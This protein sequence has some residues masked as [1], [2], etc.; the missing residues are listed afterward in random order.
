MRYPAINDHPE[1]RVGIPQLSGGINVS[2]NPSYINDN[3][4]TACK[5]M[6]FSSGRL[7][8]RPGISLD[9]VTGIDQLYTCIIGGKLYLLSSRDINGKF[10]EFDI[11][12]GFIVSISSDQQGYSGDRAA[13]FV[14]R[15]DDGALFIYGYNPDNDLKEINPYIPTV[16]INVNPSLPTDIP[17][18][19]MYQ[20][21]NLLTG[22]YKIACNTVCPGNKYW[23][24]VLPV[25][26]ANIDS[27]KIEY[28]D[29]NHREQQNA[30]IRVSGNTSGNR[31]QSGD[32]Y[33]TILNN[34]EYKT[35]KA[36]FQYWSEYNSVVVVC[37]NS[38]SQEYQCDETIYASQKNGLMITVNCSGSAG[39]SKIAS[40]TTGRW[41]GGS[42]G[43][44][45]NG[46]RLF[47]AGGEEEG[48]IRWSDLNKPNYFS[49]NTYA[50]I[51]DGSKITA[52]A[53]QD[54]ML[55]IFQE[56]AITYAKYVEGGDLSFEDIQNENIPDITTVTGSF[57]LTAIHPTVGCDCP[58]TVQLCNNRLVWLTSEG[59]VY[60]LVNSNQYNERNVREISYAIA[61]M[62]KKHTAD[63]LKT[64][65]SA[66]AGGMYF[67]FVGHKI[68]VLDYGN[69]SFEYYTYYSQEKKLK[70]YLSWYVWELPES[71]E[72]CTFAHGT[73]DMLSFI[74]N[75]IVEGSLLNGCVFNMN[76]NPAQIKKTDFRII[77]GHIEETSP[78]PCVMRTKLF[79]FSGAEKM[80]R[81]TSCSIGMCKIPG[82]VDISFITD[83]GSGTP[84]HVIMD[85]EVGEED[86]ATVNNM[87]LYPNASCTGIFGVEIRSDSAM[88]VESIAVNYKEMGTHQ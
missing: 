58:K 66:D 40:M 59:K 76:L 9:K 60:C 85:E 2:D 46:S 77:D 19:Y 56:H 18:G 26:S 37:F 39:A 52:L 41:F 78:I 1:R 7:R 42:R 67:L 80:K 28:Y 22:S 57:P 32:I 3:Q 83:N 33:A 4:L 64:A 70:N 51:G 74:G 68:Y 36:R 15:K 13:A 12:N 87:T 73:G 11:D 63:E 21:I 35:V 38:H 61:P 10:F 55:V 44:F 86:P 69:T 47:T 20:G 81:I 53:Q 16:K 71:V 84:R 8:T 23:A 50:Y 31:P 54:D 72:S 29:M 82:E 17:N 14:R 5:N 34:G 27:I 48:I 30:F 65:A 24:W 75:S 79:A 45:N 62:L 88:A 25:T 49:E 43:G 6:W